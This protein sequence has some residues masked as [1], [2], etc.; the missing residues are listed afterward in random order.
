MKNFIYKSFLA[1]ALCSGSGYAEAQCTTVFDGCD[2]CG[3][4]ILSSPGTLLVPGSTLRVNPVVTGSG[5][6][7]TNVS[8]SPSGPTTTFTFPAITPDTVPTD[9]VVPSV[10]T[11]YTVTATMLGPNL[12][13]NPDFSRGDSCFS[14][15]YTFYPRTSYPPP[16]GSGS[17]MLERKY[18]VDTD[19]LFTHAWGT[20]MVDHTT[21]TGKMGIFNGSTSS[22]PTAWGEDVPI[23]QNNDYQFSFWHAS[24]SPSVSYQMPKLK[25]I[26]NGV[27]YGPY[28]ASANAVWEKVEF[29]FH[30]DVSPIASIQIIDENTSYNG[31]DFV[32]DDISLNR[33]CRAVNSITLNPYLPASISTS[34]NDLNIEITPNPSNGIISVKGISNGVI[35]E[36][37]AKIEILNMLGQIVQTDIATIS[38]GALNKDIR[39]NNEL[40]N[41]IYLL[42]TYIGGKSE[43]KRFELNK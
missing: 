27:G 15:A 6:I 34:Q 30:N 37:S 17:D 40:P 22:L 33:I 32:L 7:L 24:W 12:I 41:G 5:F 19:P 2:A 11:T 38:Q 39:L 14:S 10:A 21:G 18:A 42:K 23:C 43:I 8:W 28:I 36:N 1:I 3:A 9:I 25:V 35:V 31:N 20:H 26:I 13:A 16:I 4:V 29:T